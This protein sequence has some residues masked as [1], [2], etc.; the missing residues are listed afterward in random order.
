MPPPTTATGSA[1]TMSANE[2]GQGADEG[3]GR[4]QRLGAAEGQPLR[5]GEG[6]GL[7]V[8]V[9]EDLGVVADETDGSHQHPPRAPP[10]QL[11]ERLLEGRAEP[12]LG[13]AACALISLAVAREPCSLSHAPGRG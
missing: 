9:E 11:A 8:D 7:H 6:T 1:G 13:C 12:R 5:A 4:V 3:R 10:G 2:V